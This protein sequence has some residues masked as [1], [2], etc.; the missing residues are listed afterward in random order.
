MT[1]ILTLLLLVIGF[2]Q[3]QLQAQ[4]IM[5]EIG[6]RGFLNTP[7]DLHYGPEGHLWVTE[8]QAGKVV[9]IN[10]E[11]GARDELLLIDDLYVD[12][13]QD[14]LL[15]MALHKDILG[16][17]PY[18]YLSYTELVNN[19]ARQKLVR[20]T[21]S[22]EG[23]DGSL[24]D[25]IVI[26]DQMPASNDHNS[27]R[28]VYGPDDK[29]Y[30]TIGDQGA[31]QNRNYCDPVLSQVL[32]TQEEIDARDWT[33]YPGKILRLNLDGS[34]PEGN[35]V[36]N[37]VRSHIYSYGHRNP[38]GIVFGS[39]GILYS[40]EHGPDTDDEVNLIEGGQNYGWPNVAGYQNDDSAYDYCNWSSSAN[41]ENIGYDKSF[42]PEDATFQEESEFTAQNFKEP[43][44]SMFAVTDSYD[45]NNPDC[46]NSWVCRP[47]VA[48]SSIGIYESDAIPG[49]KN[50]LLVTS[51]KRGRIYRLQLSEDGTEMIGDTTQHFYSHNR[52]R[53]VVVDPDGNSFY[54]ITDETGR[55]STQNDLGQVNNLSH[56]GM[57]LKFTYAP[58]VATVESF[59]KQIT[60]FPNPA[61][62]VLY[63]HVSVETSNFTGRILTSDGRTI[64]QDINFK[65]GENLID[66]GG[67]TS[68][69][70]Y[71][72][73]QQ[74][75]EV[76]AKK[77][78]VF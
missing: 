30:Y 73:L 57:I 3:V 49:W 44:L 17:E 54:V 53:D 19:E 64:I 75:D 60:I 18:V 65:A 11:S 40:D 38:Q 72:R 59:A 52:Y 35:P 15:G 28:L 26:L 33:N 13:R 34:I 78:I 12:S 37:G 43:L 6:T 16:S 31:N 24:T 62:Q 61:S 71:L 5:T 70:Y 10:K 27:G 42:C 32:P 69:V 36:L 48:P 76:E 7:W 45:F 25:P 50:S 66:I 74:G 22:K 51:L 46:T 14:G 23:D 58:S 8:R 56:P 2:F 47:N 63:V 29:L 39:N 55:L 67:L 9:R 4:F 1:R 77:L 20:Y 21:Y 41:C 68:G